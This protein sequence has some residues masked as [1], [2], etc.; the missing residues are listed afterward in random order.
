MTGTINLNPQLY[1]VSY[2]SVLIAL[3]M[4]TLILCLVLVLPTICPQLEAI[5]TY[6]SAKPARNLVW[7]IGSAILFLSLYLVK[8]CD[9]LLRFFFSSSKIDVPT[10]KTT[11]TNFSF[12]NGEIVFL[13]YL[14]L[15]TAS[16]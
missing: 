15:Q 2:K 13:S 6:R 8:V 16:K 12:V 11:V 5:Q 9:I 10:S 1:I 4:Y 14:S 3:V 7:I